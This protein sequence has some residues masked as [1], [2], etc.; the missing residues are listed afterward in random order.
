MGFGEWGVAG[1][2]C[3]RTPG[4]A[5]LPPPRGRQWAAS[6]QDTFGFLE[7]LSKYVHRYGMFVYCTR[8][9]WHSKNSIKSLLNQ[10]ESSGREEKAR[11]IRMSR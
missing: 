3:T 9:L 6:G 4:P 7:A 10:S 8:M 1:E 11:E 2:R 5:A